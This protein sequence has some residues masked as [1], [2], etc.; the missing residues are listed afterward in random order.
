M[1]NE[2]PVV[3]YKIDI[4]SFYPLNDNVKREGREWYSF[5]NEESEGFVQVFLTHKVLSLEDSKVWYLGVLGKLK[6]VRHVIVIDSRE[7]TSGGTRICL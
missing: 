7:L 6:A 4:Y 5:W 1:N 3:Y 2:W